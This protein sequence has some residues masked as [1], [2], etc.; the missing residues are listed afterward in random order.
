MEWTHGQHRVLYEEIALRQDQA[1]YAAFLLHRS[2]TFTMAVAIKDAIEV[3]VPGL[4]K[5]VKA[6]KSGVDRAIREAIL[7]ALAISCV[8]ETAVAPSCLTLAT[9]K[10]LIASAMMD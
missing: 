6:T 10:L 2:S 8:I 3:L 5:A 9:I 7:R 4:P 1:G